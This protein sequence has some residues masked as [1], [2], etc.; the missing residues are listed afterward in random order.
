M[1]TATRNYS[2]TKP[3]YM[4]QSNR[5]LTKA[6]IAENYVG[7][8]ESRKSVLEMVQRIYAERKAQ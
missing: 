4:A 8:E 7:V 2:Q 5:L 6:E 1:S 3:N